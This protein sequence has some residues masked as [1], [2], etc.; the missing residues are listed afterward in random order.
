MADVMLAVMAVLRQEDETLSG[1]ISQIAGDS[2]GATRF[3][4]ASHYHPELALATYY[5]SMSRDEALQIA[6]KTLIAKYADPLR[7]GEI[8]DQ[9]VATKLLSYDVNEDP[10]RATEALQRAINQALSASPVAVDGKMG[11]FT[12]AAANRCDPVS[13]LDAFKLQMIARYV[14]HA[15]DNVL[16]G[17]LRRA[18]A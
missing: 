14:A 9:P 2:G 16:R 8:A 3:G 15:Q 10:E 17:L 7:I 12:V 11:P 18:L 6:V 13:L 4:L 1:R 5:T